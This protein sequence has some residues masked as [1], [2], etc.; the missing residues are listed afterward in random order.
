MKRRRHGLGGT[1]D[2]H[3]TAVDARVNETY[4]QMERPGC[5]AAMLALE[6]AAAVDAEL[7]WAM[8]NS[9]SRWRRERRQANANRL[10]SM[11]R[12]NLLKKCACRRED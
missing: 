11:A 1:D 8:A 2:Q 6:S 5:R 7:G 10:S 3:N 12:R 9:G 4:F